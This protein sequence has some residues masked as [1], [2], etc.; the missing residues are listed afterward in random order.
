MALPM[1]PAGQRASEVL[2][3]NGRL[4]GS[5]ACSFPFFITD[6]VNRNAI[7]NELFTVRPTN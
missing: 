6:N 1:G 4:E 2:A 3:S 7:P 5:K